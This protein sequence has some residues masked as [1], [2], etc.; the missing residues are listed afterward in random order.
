[1]QFKSFFSCRRN[2]SLVLYIA[3]STLH[4]LCGTLVVLP[5]VAA[6]L[7]L[8][9]QLDDFRGPRRD[10]SVEAF[11]VTIILGPIVESA[12]TV[13]MVRLLGL[14][15]IT[16]NWRVALICALLWGALHAVALPIWFF[17]VVISFYIY[18]YGYLVWIESS[19][20]AA[21]LALAVPHSAINAMVMISVLISK[22]LST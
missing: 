8:T 18:T 22:S 1:M 4:A 15:K 13:V 11:I 2:V 14:L 20:V 5:L 12:V 16:E 7:F 17:G 21:W 9:G 10:L 6:Y 19:A 3:R